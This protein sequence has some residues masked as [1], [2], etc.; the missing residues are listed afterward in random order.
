MTK[1]QSFKRRVRERM[2]KT[3]ESYTA[4]RRQLLNKS[5]DPPSPAVTDPAAPS[6]TDPAVW[7]GTTDESVRNR[8]GRGWDD[9][10][11]LLDEWDAATRKHPEIARWLVAEHGV[12]GWWAQN[13]T[14]G[15]EQARGIRAVGQRGDGS[16]SATASKT[17]NVPV[18]RL[19]DAFTDSELRQ[20]WLPDAAFA[21]RSSRRP[22]SLRADW[23]D[24]STR[25]VFGFTAKGPSKSQVAL[26][27]ERLPDAEHAAEMK[28]YWRDRVVALKGLLEAAGAPA[29]GD[30]VQN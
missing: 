4:A 27:H 20:R 24:G 25:V 29:E 28:A 19:F 5:L 3:Q 10:F 8:T 15:Y 30:G 9:W 6:G 18:D 12:D 22:K 2:A 14:V 11:A 21:I 7:S 17:V 13:I 16:Y 26:E 23:E 1:Q